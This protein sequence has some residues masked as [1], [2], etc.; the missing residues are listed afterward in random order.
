M[1][2]ALPPLNQHCTNHCL[3]QLH[4]VYSMQID[5]SGC[6]SQSLTDV[7]QCL[8]SK[9]RHAYMTTSILT[10]ES[11]NERNVFKLNS[12]SSFYMTGYSGHGIA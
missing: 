7:L 3:I 1:Y 4:D 2:R 11:G 10:S 12:N 9:Y 8:V 6:F 5:R